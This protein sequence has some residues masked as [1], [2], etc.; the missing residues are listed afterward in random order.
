MT[1]HQ[2]TEALEK[3][4]KEMAGCRLLSVIY[5]TVKK[6]NGIIR[7][8]LVI[9]RTACECFADDLSGRLL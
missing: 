8:G 7:S 5:A 1:Y 6:N 4:V 9:S 3:S 2:F